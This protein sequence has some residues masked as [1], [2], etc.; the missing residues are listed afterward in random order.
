LAAASPGASSAI[1]RLPTAP[2]KPAKIAAV[3]ATRS[4][5]P[6][7]RHSRADRLF[8]GRRLATAP[9]RGEDESRPN[10]PRTA[11]PRS[12][13]EGLHNQEIADRLGLAVATI[14]V[15][16]TQLFKKMRV[17]SRL[18]AVI[19]AR[20]Q[21]VKR[22]PVSCPLINL[23]TGWSCSPGKV[24]VP[25]PGTPSCRGQLGHRAHSN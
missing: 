22:H 2:A 9:T 1:G 19:A 3:S 11:T 20:N 14:K 24:T 8:V 5:R 13:H 18:Q 10:L 17:R 21:T 4:C 6:T 25:I 7:L 16:L 12:H 15:Y 23:C